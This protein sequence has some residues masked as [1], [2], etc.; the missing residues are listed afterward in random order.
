MIRRH[1][2]SASEPS[3]RVGS[4]SRIT[5]SMPS[6]VALGDVADRA[7]DDAGGVRRGRP[8]D[9]HELPVASRSCSTNCPAVTVGRRARGR[10][11]LD[12]L[13]R[14]QRAAPARGDDAPRALVERLQRP[15]RRIVDLDATPWPGGAKKRSTPIAD[16]DR[17]RSRSRAR[18]CSISMPRPAVAGAR[19]ATTRRISSGSSSMHRP[20]VQ[21]DAVPLQPPA[22]RPPRL[23]A[24]DALEGLDEHPLE[25]RQRRRCA[26]SSS[27]TGVRSRTSASANSRSSL[28]FARAT[29]WNT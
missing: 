10:Q 5:R 28:G 15:R 18:T 7:D 21:Q 29:P 11:Q 17:R 3:A 12:D 8:V 16:A 1:S 23:E 22:R 20:D 26:P 14:M 4:P 19:R 2:G 13:G 25:L 27:R 24:A 6:R 9:R